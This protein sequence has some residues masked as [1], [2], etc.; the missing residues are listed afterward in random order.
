MILIRADSSTNIGTGHTMR[1]LSLAIDLRS[2]GYQ[3]LFLVKKLE[4]N[5][6]YKLTE[7]NFNFKILNSKNQASEIIEVKQYIHQLN[8]TSLIIDHYEIQSQYEQKITD[9]KIITI[10]DLF[11]KH[12]CDLLWNPNLYAKDINYKHLVPEKTKFFCGPEYALLREGFS[13]K[14]KKPKTLPSPFKLL[15]TLG[16]SDPKNIS[17]KII[18][19]LLKN[20]SKYFE[21]NIILGPSNNHYSSIHEITE[22]YQNIQIYQNP[23]NIIDLMS[24]S[25]IAIIAGGT[26][27]LEIINLSIPSILIQI[28]DNQKYVIKEMFDRNLCLEIKKPSQIGIALKEIQSKYYDFSKNLHA[29]SIGEKYHQLLKAIS[30]LNTSPYLSLSTNNDSIDIFNLANDPII[31]KSSFNTNMITLP[32]HKQWF[33]KQLSTKENILYSI[34]DTYSEKFLGLIRFKKEKS[35][36]TY[37][38]SISLGNHLRGCKVSSS[39]INKSIAM[40]HAYLGTDLLILAHIKPSNQTSIKAFTNSNFTERHSNKNY[41]IL[42]KKV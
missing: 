20:P 1:C 6:N 17:L 24:D 30:C 11:F 13:K 34:K 33:K 5:I 10:D 38:I 25:H 36:N 42:E 26:T 23:K 28:A 37:I 14:V 3:C 18:K 35:D 29:I 16:G 7:L 15:L 41:L 12:H 31:R 8:A 27:A 19:E 32:E 39:L 2:Q 4:G 21:L 40:L 22:N 9:T